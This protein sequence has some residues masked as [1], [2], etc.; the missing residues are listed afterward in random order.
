MKDIY[1][2]L[3]DQSKR[4]YWKFVHTVFLIFETVHKEKNDAI[5][6]TLTSELEKIAQEELQQVAKVKELPKLNTNLAIKKQSKKNKNS[7]NNSN[8][9]D[10]FDNMIKQFDTSKLTLDS[11]SN[12]GSEMDLSKIMEMLTSGSE[13]SSGSQDLMSNM[14]SQL[15]KTDPEMAN[16]MCQL[17]SQL[18]GGSDDENKPLD[19]KNILKTFMPNIE[20][21]T[22]EDLMN[23]MMKDITSTISNISTTDDI[24]SKTKQLGEK[25]QTMIVNG[26]I[27]PNEI[28][29]SLMG[30]MTDNKFTEQLSNIDVSHLKPEDMIGKMMSE[31]SP[32]L[33]NQAMSS[34]G[35]D[36][37]GGEGSNSNAGLGAMLSTVMGSITGN[38]SVENKKEEKE[39][40]VEQLKE[41]EDYYSKLNIDTDPINPDVD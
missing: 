31:V 27:N 10:M 22:N 14:L 36:G 8:N 9:M 17:V 1:S 41:L 28:L 39:L 33:L 40:T 30:L 2:D 38:K 16:K 15:G 26:E 35:G 13:T 25:Y 24:F 20:E 21:S 32:E 6:N 37:S 5:I 29:G 18:G 4:E 19:M 12:S 34:M 11:G 7:N 23:N 3:M